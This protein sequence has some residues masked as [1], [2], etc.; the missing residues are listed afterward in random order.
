MVRDA[1]YAFPDEPV[2]PLF[3]V[4]LA[5]RIAYAEPNLNRG[6]T[7]SHLISSALLVTHRKLGELETL[8]RRVFSEA[9]PSL[10][11]IDVQTMRDEVDLN[12]DQQRSVA[13]LAGLFGI[14]ALI[15]AA[16]GLYG[17]TAMLSPGAQAKSACAWLWAPIAP[18]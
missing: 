18:A 3:F 8:L 15:L 9:D 5:Q 17:V 4:P 14:V 7:R 6:E 10:T 12:F 16:I 2:H 13:D 1:R 11:I